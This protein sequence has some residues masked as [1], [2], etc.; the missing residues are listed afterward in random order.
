MTDVLLKASNLKAA[1]GQIE[2][3]HGVNFDVY[4]NEMVVILGANG[5]GK[6]TTIRALSGM[7]E[8]TGTITFAQE[9]ISQSEPDDIVRKGVAHV[10]QG[11][12]TFPE[13]TVEENLRVGAFIRSDNDVEN[14]IQSCYDTYPVLFDRRTQS[15]GSLS[16]G[17]QQMLAV[18]RALMSKPKLLLLDEPSLGLAPQIVEALFEQFLAMNKDHGTT[19]LIVEQNAQIALGMADRGYVLEAG[20][21]VAEGK[22]DSLINDEAIKRAYLGG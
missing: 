5:A 18:S 12:G 3:L 20:E 19:M 14:D 2:V 17:E 4:V 11:R 7:V 8:T 1:Y 22:A 10:P 9:D 15:A 13:L 16:G 21:I 6:T